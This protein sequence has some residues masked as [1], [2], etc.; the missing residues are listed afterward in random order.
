MLLGLID[1]SEGMTDIKDIVG[2]KV[3]SKIR[4]GYMGLLKKVGD[5]FAEFAEKMFGHNP[6]EMTIAEGRTMWDALVMIANGADKEQ[7][8][9]NYREIAEG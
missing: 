4:K 8:I 9:N 7:T 3:G 6:Q 2:E 1:E 5:E